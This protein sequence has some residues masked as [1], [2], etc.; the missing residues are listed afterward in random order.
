M[1]KVAQAESI[2][3]VYIHTDSSLVK[4]VVGNNTTFICGVQNKSMCNNKNYNIII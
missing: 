1:M 4:D 2:G 3:A